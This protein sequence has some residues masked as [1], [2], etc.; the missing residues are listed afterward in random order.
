M[1]SGAALS[2]LDRADYESN[3]FWES[4]EVEVSIK[5]VEKFGIPHL[6]VYCTSNGTQFFVFEILHVGFFKP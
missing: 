4:R 6:L 2:G 1:L 5:L 3:L